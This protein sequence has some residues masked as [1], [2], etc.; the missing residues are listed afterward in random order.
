MVRSF[1]EFAKLYLLT[2]KARSLG[3]VEHFFLPSR[4]VQFEDEDL[5]LLIR[6]LRMLCLDNLA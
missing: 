1:T 3:R 4:S 5:K 6:Y 2:N